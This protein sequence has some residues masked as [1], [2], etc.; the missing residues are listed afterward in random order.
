M[1]L[2]LV[3]PVIFSLNLNELI[4]LLLVF[5]GKPVISFALLK[6]GSSL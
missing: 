1:P 2:L 6:G 5:A 4:L 3:W